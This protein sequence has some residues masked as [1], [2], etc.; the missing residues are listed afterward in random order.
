M[1]SFAIVLLVISGSEEFV[2][3]SRES[4]LRSFNLRPIIA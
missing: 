1:L 2:T 3:L 4:C